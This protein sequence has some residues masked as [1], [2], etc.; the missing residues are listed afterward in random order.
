MTEAKSHQ[1]DP[2]EVLKSKDML[3]VYTFAVIQFDE[4]EKGKNK[5]STEEIGLKSVEN[6]LEESTRREN[7]MTSDVG[8]LRTSIEQIN[9]GGKSISVDLY[10]DNLLFGF[11]DV[12]EGESEKALERSIFR[13]LSEATEQNLESDAK[14]ET[15]ELSEEEL[16]FVKKA[17]P[18]MAESM[19]T[20]LEGMKQDNQAKAQ[21]VA[22]KREELAIAKEEMVKMKETMTT[23]IAALDE[24]ELANGAPPYPDSGDAETQYEG[25]IARIQW[26]F[27]QLDSWD[28]K[29]PRVNIPRGTEIARKW[30]FFKEIGDEYVLLNK[31]RQWDDIYPESI[32][33]HR[34]PGETIA[35][36][37]EGLMTGRRDV[38][39]QQI[40]ENGTISDIDWEERDQ[41]SKKL[42][43]RHDELLRQ[44]RN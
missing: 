33:T 18:K 32:L 43:S 4:I 15:V 37:T 39:V 23:T 2:A 22:G 42:K 29:R 30:A 14:I 11:W 26:R 31:G 1:G 19:S 24:L 41:L 35:V 25:Y 40:L 17:F 6:R 20:K 12:I 44:V 38:S 8:L 10:G 7:R 21:E 34:V 16:A 5:I 36:H 9:G 13:K 27:S 28:S 3:E